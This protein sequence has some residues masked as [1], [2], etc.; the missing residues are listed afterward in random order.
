[1]SR[2]SPD[3]A[4]RVS[5]VALLVSSTASADFP[6]LSYTPDQVHTHVS[7]TMGE[8]AQNQPTALDG[9]LL[10]AG[11]A[12]HETWDVSDP[13]RPVHLATFLSPH[14]DGEAESHQVALQR[15]WDGRLL[16]AMIS[17]RGVDLWDLT[18]PAAPALLS[19]LELE[20]IDYGDNTEAVWG[21][22]W[23]GDVLFVGGTNTGL[24]LVD[25]TDVTAPFAIDRIPMAALGGVVAGPTWIVGDVL[26]TTTPKDFAGLAT[27]D[28]SDPRDPAVLD[29]IVPETDS[30]IGGF[31]G[32]NA[33]LLTPFRAYDVLTDPA[34]ITEIVNVPSPRGEYLAFGDDTMFFG[35][36]RPTPG[37]QEVDVSDPADP[38]VGAFVPG[39]KDGIDSGIFTD[40]QFPLPLGNLVVLCDDE[41]RHGCILAVRDAARDSTPPRVLATRPADGATGIAP[42]ASI[43]VSLSDQIHPGSVGPE[44]FEV[45]AL[46]GTVVEGAYGIQQTLV[47]FTPHTPLDL[48]TTYEIVL[49]AD[50]LADL[51]GNGLTTARRWT[52]AT[53]ATLD[54]LDCDLGTLSPIVAGSS[55]TLAPAAVS[56]DVDGAWEIEGATVAGV[57]VDHAFEAPGRHRVALTV[58]R[59]GLSRT[60]TGTQIVHR[61][62]APT[63]PSA[64]SAV[65]LSAD[66]ATAYVVDA[67]ADQLAAVDVATGALRWTAP[68][69]DHPEAVTVDGEGQVWVA[70]R[71]ADTVSAFD[72]T[73]A[74]LR[75]LDL[76]YGS[77]PRAVASDGDRVFVAASARGTVLA[78]DPDGSAVGE[79]VL[80]DTHGRY[81]ALGGLAV[82]GD[83]VLVTRRRS[84]PDGGAV[85]VLARDL[86]GAE[87]V[88]PLAVDPGPDTDRSGR[89][90]PTNLGAVAA[91]PDGLRLVV[92]GTKANLERGLLR[93]GEVLDSDNTVR[94]VID[95]LDAD[96]SLAPARVDL[97]DHEGPVAAVFSPRGDVVFVASRGSNQVDA[98]DAVTGQLLGGVGVGAAPQ[99]LALT[100]DG[101][102]LV[103]ETL[104]RRLARFDVSGLLDGTDGVFVPL[105]RTTT[106]ETEPLPE[107]VLLGKRLFHSADS[108]EMSQDGY[109]S[110]ASCHPDGADD[111]LV[112]DFT[113]RGEGL[114]NTLDLRGRAG[115]GHGPLHWSANFDE[116]Q[117]FEHDLRW[118]FGGA[119]L[120]ADEDFTTEGRDD[121]LGTPK[122]GVSDRLDALA[123]YVTSLDTFPR[124]PYRADDGSFTEAALRGRAIF[125]RLD[126]AECHSGDALTDSPE[127]LRHDVG[128]LTAASGQRLGGDLDGLDTPTLHG[129]WATPP[130]LHDGSAPTL[131]DVLTREGHGRA[132]RLSDAKR[133][134]LVAYLRQLDGEVLPYEG[135]GCA[136]PRGGGGWAVLAGLAGLVARRRRR[137]PSRSG[138]A[139]PGAVSAR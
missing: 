34:S 86:D 59:D 9:A 64:S 87:A 105:G 138:P 69:G 38:V 25:T 88:L 103:H 92:P 91:S 18:D 117:D 93:D 2:V 135:C 50:G 139:G 81:L 130:Y 14:A 57:T 49:P 61:P 97:D 48:D 16:A 42:T 106:V 4:L 40:D 74:L 56:D 122:A 31:Y 51:V 114:R 128:T 107:D 118:H 60:C 37:V 46:D 131:D 63:P 15:T 66:G 30:Y 120:M 29:W 5:L 83:R 101:V 36:L 39:R 99:A 20:G 102:L 21:V 76:P 98:L 68:T 13:T 111:G 1:M 55:T 129:V 28:V 121:P 22:A 52:F 136:H 89:G 17:G 6:N 78:Y 65:A 3:A 41:I 108:R 112:W 125:E 79:Q 70:E 126:C 73:G 8:H 109:I 45:R 19:A 23:A 94:T 72:A 82:V 77:A 33:W 47:T 7:P 75:T 12:R 104:D 96:G 26:V 71:D 53:G 110:C 44:A 10:F 62:A 84:T 27:L 137:V 134:D 43:T 113:D 85:H 100:P 95:L 32:G 58:T 119:G 133:A 116:V 132:Q 35:S 90:V 115:T 80:L 127:G 24:H 123:A 11:N 54:R 124:S 67:D